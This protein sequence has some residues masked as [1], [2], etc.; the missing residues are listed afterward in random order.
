VTES[1]DLR[2]LAEGREAEIF[3][4]GAGSVIR[5]MR[6]PNALEQVQLEALAMEAARAAG[7]RVPDVLGT[8]TVDG[9]PGLVMERIDGTDLLTDI[10]RRPWTMPRAAYRLGAIHALL[11][12]TPAP[13]G[14]APLKP[15]LTR[16][17]E[18]SK[19]V[20]PELRKLALSALEELPDGQTLL[21]GDFHPGNVIQPEG[22]P[23]LLDWTGV[24]AGDPTADYVR[25][26]L[27]LGLGEP[28]PGTSIVLRAALSARHL[29]SWIYS[30]SYE[31]RRPVDRALAARWELPVAAGRLAG[32]VESERPA[33]LRIVNERLRSGG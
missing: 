19:R 26:K 33:L 13:E 16:R 32:G 7:V 24:S 31:R 4:W 25:T 30:R 14:V 9:R 21:H 12:S 5:L 11:H 1:R 27:L 28:P 29:F 2:R 20:P 3:E 23:V 18:M 15:S 10:G 22:G 8:A 6:D 17:I